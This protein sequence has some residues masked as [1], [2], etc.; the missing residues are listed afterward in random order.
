MSRTSTLKAAAA[1]LGLLTGF[2]MAPEAQAPLERDLTPYSVAVIWKV[3]A[4]TE[5]PSVSGVQMDGGGGRLAPAPTPPP[6]A[7]RAAPR[8]RVSV[9]PPAAKPKPGPEAPR[10][11]EE[12]GG[13]VLRGA[14][15]AAATFGLSRRECP[16]EAVHHAH[17]LRGTSES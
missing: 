6:A 15:L 17:D 12:P 14:E 2:V 8:V 3:N 4:P 11:A 10:A 13:R 1:A 7:E 9:R 5:L 16:R